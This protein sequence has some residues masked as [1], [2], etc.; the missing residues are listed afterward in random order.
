METG[1]A[2]YVDT[3]SYRIPCLQFSGHQEDTA[4]LEKHAVNLVYT[5]YLHPQ[6]ALSGKVLQATQD[7]SYS[8]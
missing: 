1:Q 7:K 6:F 2:V 5:P 4:H 3:A 8:N